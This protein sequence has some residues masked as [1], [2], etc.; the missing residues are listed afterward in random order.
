VSGEITP[1]LLKTRGKETLG[2]HW[3]GGWV[4]PRAG[5]H[6]MKLIFF[7][8]LGLELLP[9]GRPARSQSV[10]RQIDSWFILYAVICDISTL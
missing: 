8:L 6:D 10:Y 2:T 4:G 9:L 7:T 1:L 5:L 3:F